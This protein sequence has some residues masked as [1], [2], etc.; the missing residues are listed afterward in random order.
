MRKRISA[1]A[2]I[3]FAAMLVAPGL[4][5]AASLPATVWFQ[6]FEEDTSG[7]QDSTNGWFG[8]ITR[9]ASGTN[10][11]S[12]ASGDFHAVMTDDPGDSGP[13][14]RFDGYRDEWTGGFVA[15]IDV[16]L[17]VD[18]AAGEGFDYSVA[19]SGTDGL[20]QRDFI[21]HVAKD[22]STGALL[23]AGDNN[24]NFATRQDLDTINHVEV[25]ESGW[26]T[27]QHV[28]RDNGGVLAVDLNLLDSDGTVL[29]TETRS[30][31]ED[32]IPDEVGGNRYSWFTFIDVTGGIAVDNHQLDVTVEVTKE[33]CKNG[34]WESF[35]FS[36]QGQC[37][38]FVNAND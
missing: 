7:W 19:A 32:T 24:S 13:F 35:G 17:N 4:V 2:V 5:M 20:H 37:I 26:Y 1:L 12:S 11:T 6:G 31:P 22:T 33:S 38:A 34:G 25:T 21:F 28:F 36:N 10:G 9:V 8:S 15:S 27:F 14:S 29:F 23:V 30:S 18:M 16:Y 3:V